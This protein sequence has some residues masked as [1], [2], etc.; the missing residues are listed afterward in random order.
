[1]TFTTMETDKNSTFAAMET[2]KNEIYHYGN[3]DK[4]T[5]YRHGNWHKMTFT[6]M[7]T[8]TKSKFYWQSDT[9]TNMDTDNKVVISGQK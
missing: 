5:I 7:E 9:A 2:G 6:T 4:N 1:M 8:G 3:A